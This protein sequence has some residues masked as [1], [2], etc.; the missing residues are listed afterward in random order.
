ME[1]TK[2]EA[3]LSICNILPS[4]LFEETIK[5]LSEIDQ[6]LT[7]NILIN[8]EG[9]IKTKFDSEEK[10]YYL[11]NMFN[12]EKDSYRSPYAN[13]YYP[14][15]F[16]NSYIPSEPLRNLEIL[17]NEIFDKY[18]KAYYISGLS[19][20]Y[21]WPNPT[22]E[23]FVGCFLIKK[24]ESFNVNTSIIWEATHLIQVNIS[25]LIIH[26]QISSTVNFYITKK[27]EIILSASINKALENPKKILDMNLLK[28]KFFHMENMGKM[29][30][31]IENSLR[32][33]IEY[34]YMPKITDI[35][36]SLRFNDLLCD[37]A[38]DEKIIKLKNICNN[39]TSSKESIQDELKLKFKNKNLN[40][41]TQYSINT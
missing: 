26:Y 12:K 9:P 14:D 40:L 10:K 33:S 24:S 32:K 36:N 41:G 7:N 30:E 19:S 15:N 39:V 5:I 16:S 31:S 20:V 21:L 25:H 27:N 8:K 13:I 35:L 22:E 28:D 17:F 6:N 4:H 23:G 37:Y 11:A 34:I 1:K 38:Y 18:R 29:I 2:V 3:A